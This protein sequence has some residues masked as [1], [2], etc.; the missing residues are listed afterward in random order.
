MG[1]KLPSAESR[2][3]TLLDKH[4]AACAINARTKVNQ[5][6]AA[7]MPD[8][9]SCIIHSTSIPLRPT[10]RNYSTHRPSNHRSPNL[11]EMIWR[12]FQAGRKAQHLRPVALQPNGHRF[13]SFARVSIE[14]V[15][16]RVFVVFE[17]RHPACL[18]NAR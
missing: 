17:T 3:Q 15:P 10:H 13:V 11:N 18:S 8:T 6:K 1:H 9:L 12:H 7:Y 2:K 16:N 5:L 14:H 4:V